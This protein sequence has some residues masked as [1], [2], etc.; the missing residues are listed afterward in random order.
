MVNKAP[1]PRLKLVVRRLPPTLPE[2]TFWSVVEPWTS[3]ALWKRYVQGRPGDNFGA[4]PVHSRAYVLMPDVASIVA[5]HTAFDGHLF[6]SKTGQ[7]FQAVVEFAPVEKTPYRVKEKKDAKQ[8]TIDNDYLSFLAARDS[9]PEP[10]EVTVSTPAPPPESTPLLDALRAQASKSKQKQAKKKEKAEKA[11]N[12]A[13]ASVAD[14]AKNRAPTGGN[15]VMV[16]GAG[17]EVYVQDGGA[18]S[19]ETSK[20]SK[21]K[22][23]APRRKKGKK[24]EAAAA[25]AGAGKDDAGEGPS[26][27]QQ[28]QPQGQAQ[29]EKKPKSKPKKKPQEKKPKEEKEKKDGDEG[30]APAAGEGEEKKPKSRNRGRGRGGG[31]GGGGNKEGGAGGGEAKESGPSKPPKQKKPREPRE[32]KNEVKASEARIDM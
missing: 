21:D 17:R 9:V 4:H 20:D 22:K 3:G 29:G 25:E 12:A 11:K 14:A 15:V 5:F 31:G 18:P 16:A 1:A 26:Q 2:A 13:L 24:P 23:K 10:V 7:E 32:P 19:E 30:A 6:R 28:Q 27:A 8:G